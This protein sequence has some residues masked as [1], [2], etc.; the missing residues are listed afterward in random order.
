MINSAAKNETP[1]VLAV[2]LAEKLPF[3]TWFFDRVFS[4]E[5]IEHVIDP[6]VF[7]D[8]VYRVL[9]RDGVAVIT[10]PNGDSLAFEHVEEKIRKLFG[11]NFVKGSSAYKD[12]HMRTGQIEKIIERSGFKIKKRIFDG[13]LYFWQSNLPDRMGLLIPVFS[14]FTEF[15]E[16]M[17][18]I[19]RMIC[20]QVKYVL[21]KE[22]NAAEDLEVVEPE[23]EK[24]FFVCPGCESTLERETSKLLCQKCNNRYP[25]REGIAHFVDDE[26][27]RKEIRSHEYREIKEHQE[28]AG[29]KRWYAGGR[30]KFAYNMVYPILLLALLPLG[31]VG[32]SFRFLTGKLKI[33]Q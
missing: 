25:I 20:D 29:R 6:Q 30:L 28:D 21:V 1:A 17:P 3:P 32:F 24:I 2:A 9:K 33:T 27:Q 23:A 22:E 18:L 14:R 16:K 19:N 7:L 8:S 5:V 31:L 13:V 15:I 10:T 12:E 26:D 11:S 4:R